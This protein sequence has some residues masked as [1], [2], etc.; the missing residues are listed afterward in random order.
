MVIFVSIYCVF[1]FSGA[2][3]LTLYFHS[4]CFDVSLVLFPRSLPYLQACHCSHQQPDQSSV[5]ARVCAHARVCA[6]VSVLVCQ[7]YCQYQNDCCTHLIL[8]F[9]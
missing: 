7:H 5:C 3:K 8:S 2:T 9:R 4:E 6:C 1:D